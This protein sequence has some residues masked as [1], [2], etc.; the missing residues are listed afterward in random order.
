MKS[1]IFTAF[2]NLTNTSNLSWFSII[3]GFR[4]LPLKANRLREQT[5]K[6]LFKTVDDI[7]ETR[8]K[9][10]A[11]KGKTIFLPPP[12]NNFWPM[13]L[14]CRHLGTPE[15]PT[16]LDL[17]LEARD[18][19]GTTLTVQQIRDQTL[20]YNTLSTPNTTT[21]S[22]HPQQKQV[23]LGWPCEYTQSCD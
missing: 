1:T 23:P 19:V 10:I 16:L 8:K 4:Q 15:K 11:E 7:I 14:I 2:T 22:Q 20:T 3:P 18:E 12:P 17:L 21:N 6:D 9:A 13:M 5:K